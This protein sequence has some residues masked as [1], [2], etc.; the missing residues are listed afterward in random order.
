M[1]KITKFQ[2]EQI[3]RDVLKHRF[4][5]AAQALVNDRAAFALAIY[6]D[7][8][9]VADRRK[10]KSLP[11]GW[12]CSENGITAQFG[13][14]SRDYE[15]VP[16][17]G[18]VY[19]S[20]AKM[21]PERLEAVNK[22]MAYSHRNGCAKVYEA[23]HAFCETYQSLKSRKADLEREVDAAERQTES[24]IASVTTFGR[25]VEIWP[26][27]APFAERYDNEPAPLPALP[28]AKLNTLLRLP[29][30]EAA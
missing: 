27:I 9:S 23:D 2:R 25:L 7:V 8:Y 11:G 29:V 5:E 17:N 1:G 6:N 16:F 21:L 13:A 12:L 22:L 24:A 10:I 3:T 18:A 28:T 26:E 19:G 4:G 14:S 30:S 20:I 15:D